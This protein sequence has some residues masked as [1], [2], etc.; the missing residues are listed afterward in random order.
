MNKLMHC[1]SVDVEGFCEGMQESFAIPENMIRSHAEQDRIE[2]N[3]E[4][5]LDFLDVN[6]IKGTFFVLG[7]T[8]EEQPHIVHKIV[9]RGHEIA[10]HSYRHLRLYNI[11]LITIREGISRSKKILEDISGDAVLGFRAPDFSIR[12]KMLYLLDIIQET[13]FIYDS[14]IYP[15]VGHDIYGV[16]HAHLEIHKL[17]NGLIE[18]PP[19]SIKIMN[20]LIPALGGGYFRLYPFMASRLILK[21]CEN[22]GR[23]TMFYVHPYEIGSHY[24]FFKNL[25]LL[26]KFRHYINIDKPKDHF[27]RLFKEFNFG[28]AIDILKS[29]N[30]V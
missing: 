19:T 25:S 4:E 1:F 30:L 15:L 14:S 11:D 26:R 6:R 13:G 5:L 16:K 21:H 9:N 7:I 18:F 27:Q 24:P 28:R 29:L 23:N 8:A 3:I 12:S 2:K 10:C 22:Q 20:I 17:P